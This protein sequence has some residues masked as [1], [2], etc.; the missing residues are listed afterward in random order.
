MVNTAYTNS[1]VRTHGETPCRSKVET[2][3]GQSPNSLEVIVQGQ[4]PNKGPNLGHSV[5]FFFFGI[6]SPHHHEFIQPHDGS[7]T[8]WVF[9]FLPLQPSRISSMDSHPAT[10]RACGSPH[11]VG[12]FLFTTNHTNLHGSTRGGLLE[13]HPPWAKSLIL[14][15]HGLG[16][17]PERHT[18]GSES[19][20]IVQGLV[21]DLNVYKTHRE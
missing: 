7:I 21:Y 1:F 16:L 5:V 8:Q 9:S 19:V 2:S 14:T 12:F 13:D 18:Y 3:T 4:H 6:F 15:V 17:S 11:L 20:P 10:G